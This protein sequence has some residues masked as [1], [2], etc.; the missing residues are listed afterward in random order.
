MFF[1]IRKA[2]KENK[3]GKIATRFKYGF[4]YQEYRE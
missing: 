1:G 4:L 3:L 2:A